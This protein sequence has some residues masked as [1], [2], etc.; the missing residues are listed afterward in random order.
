MFLAKPAPTLVALLLAFATAALAA[1]E[2]AAEKPKGIV[3]PG[4]GVMLDVGQIEVPVGYEFYDGKTTRAFMKAVGEPVSGQ[5]VGLLMPTNGNFTV[6]F[7]FSDIG[8]VKD[9][10]KDKLDAEK[11]LASIKRGN[12][13]GNKERAKAG[14]PPLEIIGWEMPPRYDDKT[15]NLEWSIRARSAGEEIL[16][17]NTRLLGRKGVMEV[18]LV[19]DPENLQATLPL[20]RQALGGYSF[21]GGQT[22][23]EYRSGDKVAK[24]GLA[25]LVVGGAAVGA[26][27]L[28]LFATLAVFLKKAWKLVVVAIAAIAAAVRKLFWGRSTRAE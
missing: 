20:F 27:K 16:N 8:Y 12:D 25:A 17:Y 15:H 7:E 11:L 18:V 22:Y 23:A 19:V 13:E 21:Q 14:N 9:D 10:D 28:G 6:F 2:K 26:A 4:K 5:E 1:Q 24:Y 3:G